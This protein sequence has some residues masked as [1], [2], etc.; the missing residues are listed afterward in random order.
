VDVDA[1]HV[2]VDGDVVGRDKNIEAATYIEHATFAAPA[3]A[4]HFQPQ[5]IDAAQLAAATAIFAALPIDA[6]P[7]PA[8]LPPGSFM[9][10]RHNPLFVGRRDQ[11]CQLAAS[12]KGGSAAAI[13]QIAAATGLGGI[14]KTQLAVEFAH[15][16]GQHFAGGVFWIDMGDPHS[17]PAKVAQCGGVDGM[18]MRPDFGA[19][20][21][22]DQV[23]LVLSAWRSLLPRLLV[24]DNCESEELF[25]QWR[26]ATG[27]CCVL[28]TSRRASWDAALGVQPL[29][30]GILERAESLAL[31][32][33]FRSD[34]PPDDAD[35]DAIAAELGDLPLAL[36]LAGSFL[37]QYRHAAS[38]APAAFLA[39]LRQPDVLAHPAL[40]GLSKHVSPTGHEHHVA[41]TFAV[42]YE[43][44][45]PDDSTDALAIQALAR[46][47]CFAPGEPIPRNLLKTTLALADEDAG[48]ALGEDAL[49]R[50]N[51][52]GLLETDAR[53][54]LTLHR[55]LA[56]FAQSIATDEQAQAAVEQAVFEEAARINREGYPAP[57]LVLLSHLR[58]IGE[59]AVQRGSGNAGGLYNELGYHLS[60]VADHAGAR[61]AYERALAI[62]EAAFGPDHPKVAIRV[63]NLGGVLKALGDHAGARA[64][65]ERAL[66]IDE[67]AFGPDHPE[68]ATMVN[69]LGGVLQD[70]GDHAGARAAYERALRIFERFLGPDHPSTRTVRGNLDSLSSK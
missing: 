49:G 52:L 60:M 10:H 34:L 53:G 3:P 9:P 14:G 35:L 63:N 51:D 16:Y 32:R 38:G 46:A 57:L 31:L 37:N 66:A 1:E 54:A 43:R 64:A 23:G 20:P 27:A 58:F 50:L 42:S 48:D 69:N 24:F 62:D 21:L 25:A 30:L 5:H 22:D 56:R 67:A 15:R 44:L 17:V 8:G 26:P 70:L 33:K 29:P 47:A 65:Y 36:H 11:L 19:L 39:R 61:A 12:L 18:T 6:L 28:I 13:G 68:V 41:R 40:A 59:A 2:K 55:L 45:R 4:L 7:D